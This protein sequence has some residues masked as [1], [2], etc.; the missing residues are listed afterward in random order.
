MFKFLLESYRSKKNRP[1]SFFINLIGMTLGLTAV[2]VIYIYVM[3]EVRHD[4]GVF[5]FSMENV[6]RCQTT[7]EMM[8]SITPSAM[9]GLIATMPEVKATT[10]VSF[11]ATIVSTEGLDKEKIMLLDAMVMDTTGLD[12]F[13]FKM[14]GGVQNAFSS[15]RNAI[16]SRKGAVKLF[17]TEDV[18]GKSIKINNQVPVQISAVMEDVPKNSTF[19]PELIYSFEVSCE[20]NSTDYGWALQA[21]GRWSEET[22]AKLNDG[23]NIDDFSKKCAQVVV[24]A[25]TKNWGNK[26][27]GDVFV[28]QFDKI[29]FSGQEGYAYAKTID[30]EQIW[31]MG[32]I[33][34][35]VLVIAIINYVNIYTARSTEI[36]KTM[37]VKA[38][39]G[40]ERLQLIGY[41]ILDSIFITFI[42]ALC[43]F[44][45]A[46]ALEPFY[47]DIIGSEIIF[48][49]SWDMILILFVGI[50]IVC[51]VIS[52]IFP[53]LALT[54]MKPLDALANRSSGGR[55]MAWVRN[56]LIVFQF[57]VSI[58]LIGSTIFINK[59]MNY[60]YTM[61]L[62]YNRENIVQVI[63][64]NFMQSKFETFRGKLLTN[65]NIENVSLQQMSPSQI[66]QYMT[67]SW[68]NTK[69]DNYTVNVTNGDQHTFDLFDI[70]VIEGEFMSD[71][72]IKNTETKWADRKYF[73]NETFANILRQKIPDFAIPYKQFAGIFKDFQHQSITQLVTPLAI[74]QIWYNTEA[75]SDAYIKINGQNLDKT[76]KFIEDTFYEVYP[77]QLYQFDFMD[78]KFAMMYQDAQLFR[79]RLLSFSILAVFIGCLGLF[80]LVGYSVQRRRKEIAIRK[81]YGSSISQVLLLLSYSFLKW[82]IISFVIAV[83]IIY[84]VATR[85]VEQYVYRTELNLWIFAVAGMVA[86]V[87]AILTVL[88]QTYRAAT[89]N[90]ATNVKAD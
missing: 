17:G 53:A 27:E 85:W 31:V 6:Y 10:H 2:I 49:L 12:V 13:P 64:S 40:A 35:L 46:K 14:V 50:P 77:E 66:S 41:V 51:G 75:N 48:S 39:L 11:G 72:Q 23:V 8:G 61:D 44:V 34:L 55:A 81:V 7:E 88:G 24:D 45:L 32:F 79:S 54:R 82:L 89:E 25:I 36:I 16:I 76:L 28:T 84:F 4:K 3:Q 15:P 22:Y 29:Y 21:W 74:S 71:E 18:V 43:A 70:D 80:A 42:S 83:P 47:I 20:T 33:A 57:T 68:G 62:G 30:P 19:S 52:G 90:P 59:Q 67:M 1:M 38:I 37:G 63:G 9:P 87:V 56:G 26:Y 58:A 86:F 73:I 60:I 5:S 69:E 78:A 65:P